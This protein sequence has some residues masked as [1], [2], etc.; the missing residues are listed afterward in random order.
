[1]DGNLLIKKNMA[2]RQ[3]QQGESL[4]NPVSGQTITRDGNNVTVGGRVLDITTNPAVGFVSNQFVPQSKVTQLQEKVLAESGQMVSSA[5]TSLEKLF[6]SET[7]NQ[8][9]AF[10]ASRELQEQKTAAARRQLESQFGGL[11]QQAGM[12]T[13]RDV[14]GTQEQLARSRGLGF[15][16]AA[17]GLINAVKMQGKERI[18]Q[19]EK[20]RQEALATLDMNAATQ[21]Q[22]LIFKELDMERTIMKDIFDMNIRN[23]TLQ[24]QKKGEARTQTEFE[25]KRSRSMLNNILELDP[26]VLEGADL[27]QLATDA[28]IDTFLLQG[29]FET[30]KL[31]SQADSVEK[32][33][34]VFNDAVTKSFDLPAGEMFSFLAPDGTNITFEGKEQSTQIVTDKGGIYLVDKNTGTVSTLK[35]PRPVA[36][37]GTPSGMNLSKELQAEF[38]KAILGIQAQKSKADAINDLELNAGFLIS[39]YGETGLAQLAVEITRLDEMGYWGNGEEEQGISFTDRLRQE[40]GEA[41]TGGAFGAKTRQVAE[42]V[43]RGLGAKEGR[44]ISPST[45]I[46]LAIGEGIKETAKPIATFVTDFIKSLSGSK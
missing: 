5:P 37:T 34:K 19:I 31:A 17:S 43:S 45:I 25:D 42:E 39:Q 16:T 24:L 13:E 12:Q 29:L 1:M 6:I 27:S 41:S 11:R 38:S 33:A 32:F 23:E 26:S 14:E 2:Q 10:E 46:P 4:V 9:E 18:G 22:E 15:S 8:K 35:E 44:F 20:Q 40:T 21:A 36:V 7:K 3:I 30:K 28:G